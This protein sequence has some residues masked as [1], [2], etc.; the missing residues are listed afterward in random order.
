MTGP[1]NDRGDDIEL[2]S[3]TS[4]A[5]YDFIAHARSDIPKLLAEVRRL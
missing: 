4:I 1:H 2:H 3:S 5:D